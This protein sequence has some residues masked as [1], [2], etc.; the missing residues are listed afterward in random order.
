M[1]ILWVS[2]HTPILRQLEALKRLFGEDVIVQQDPRPF[3]SAEEIVQRYR[4]GGYDEMVIVAPES[5]VRRI[6]D[7]GIKPLRAEMDQVLIQ[8]A[9]VVARGRG[10]RFNR[11]RRIVGYRIDYE[12]LPPH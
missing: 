4:S 12:E 1:K 6:V 8:E 11:F 7:L 2:Q 10:Y 9:E 3:S 5:V